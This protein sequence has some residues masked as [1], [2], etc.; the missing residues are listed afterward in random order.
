MIVRNMLFLISMMILLGFHSTAQDNAPW[1]DLFNGKNFDGWTKKNGTAKYEIENK[2]IIGISEMGTPNTFM[3]TEKNYDDFI[4]EMDVKL[5]YGL[6]SGCQIRSN[7]LP[8]YRDGRVHGYQVELDPSERR[9]TAGIY[10]EARRGW[11]YPLT[12]NPK[13][14]AAFKV[15]DWNHIRIEA[16]GPEIRTWVN[17]VQCANLV[18]DLTPTGFIGLQVHS[19]H[20]EA[21]VGKTIRWKN[22]R[23]LTD[24]LE[25]YRRTS[26]PDVPQFNFS[27]GLTEQEKRTGWRMLWDGKTSKGWRGAKLEDFPDQGWKMEDGILTVMESGGGESRHGGDIV[28]IN[29]FSDFELV[30]DFK[31]TEG[32]NS[33][34]KYFVDPALNKGEGSAIGLE[35]QV[36]DD[37]VHPDAKKGVGGNRTVGS[38]Y[39]LIRADNLSESNRSGKRVSPT[40]WNR[41]RILVQGG[42]VE[43]WLNN[44][45]VVEFDRWSQMFA[46][47]V[48]KSKYAKW[49]N[50]GRGKAGHILLQDHGNTVSYKNI[51]IREF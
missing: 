28:T 9:W 50:F 39:D 21:L 25:K 23:I 20:D 38:L 43:H 46:A 32:A 49:D 36:L 51:K 16:I 42:H 18:D 45:K 5:A 6:N 8:S 4:L 19:I 41:A 40:G 12:R 34:I 26:D 3:C 35:Y 31:M 7:S 13:G 44:I 17:D 29:T 48:E 47:L 22:I 2:T 11:L 14:A 24:D 15:G 37:K 27:S 1:K 10:D 30:L 33:G